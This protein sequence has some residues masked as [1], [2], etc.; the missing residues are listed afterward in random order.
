M[1]GGGGGA[2]LT[3]LMAYLSLIYGD[4]ARSEP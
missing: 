1:N 3:L 2:D 4:N